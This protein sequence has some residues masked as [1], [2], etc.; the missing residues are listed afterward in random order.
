VRGVS[1]PLRTLLTFGLLMVILSPAEA[2]PR[3]LARVWQS[4]DGLPSNVVRAVA[5]AA[6]GYLWVGTAE[7]VVRFDGKR[8]TRVA[9]TRI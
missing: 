9:P 3:F 6:D 7:G 8:F 2:A 4:E 1:P 5:Q